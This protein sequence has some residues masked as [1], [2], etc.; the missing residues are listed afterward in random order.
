[1]LELNGSGHFFNVTNNTFYAPALC[2]GSWPSKTVQI[3]TYS[4]LMTLSLVGNVL[5][6]A[7][8]YRSK[9]PR[10]AVHYFIVNMA[11][12][13]LTTPLITL[14]WWISDTY[15]DGFW[16]VDGVLGI[17]LCKLA[18]T[19]WNVSNFVSL[20]SM[21]MIAGERFHAVLFPMKTAIFSRNKC[22]LSIIATWVA[23]LAFHA[24]YLL[25]VKLIPRDN[26]LFNCK[27]QW[28]PISYT[29]EVMEITWIS[30]ASL[31]SVC[32]IVLTVLYSSI[33]ISL[34]RKKKSLHM[35]NE[36]IKIRAKENRQI[37]YMLVVIVVVF[38][39]AWIPPNVVASVFY[40]KPTTRLPC[41]SLWLADMVLP[42]L[43]PVVY[44]AVYYT[45]NEQYRQGFRELLCC[46]WPCANKCKECFQP[47]VSP[48]G[49]NNVHKAGQVNMENTELQPR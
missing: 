15:H 14:P 26:G 10:T 6:V 12:S 24:H 36:V 28:E 19:A 16:L 49:E 40:I 22:W 11:I 9:T 38:Y 37:T 45:F 20:F 43:Y 21:M 33:V 13:D 32:A 30:I 4:V 7:V 25:A 23:S 44:P 5:V 46:P 3:F 47:S 1:M 2:T 39:I 17:V 27:L 41:F 29:R 42:L 8:F 31:I 18:K 35:A 48:Q 34:H